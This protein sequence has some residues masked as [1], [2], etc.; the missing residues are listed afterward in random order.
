MNLDTLSVS[1]SN[2]LQDQL[3]INTSVSIPV[4]DYA[5][6]C[7]CK[8]QPEQEN[9]YFLNWKDL[10]LLLTCFWALSISTCCVLI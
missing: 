3:Q 7:R 2:I 4:V 1:C 9:P 5:F 10:K 6:S 8:S